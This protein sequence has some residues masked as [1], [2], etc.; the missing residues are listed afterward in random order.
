VAI[1]SFD[2]LYNALT[3]RRQT[4]QHIKLWGVLDLLPSMVPLGGAFTHFTNLRSLEID[5]MVLMG[6]TDDLDPQNCM[7]AGIYGP[8]PSL[9]AVW[10]ACCHPPSKVSTSTANLPSFATI[11]ISFWEFVDDLVQVPLLRIFGCRGML[12]IAFVELSAAMSKRG[13]ELQTSTSDDG[14]ER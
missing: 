2:S 13:I 12:P 4:L 10:P 7:K 14:Y 5:D 1:T 8:S 9:A 6:I 11:P 3:T